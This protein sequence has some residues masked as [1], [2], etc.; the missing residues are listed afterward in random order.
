MKQFILI[1]FCFISF[2]ALAG[3]IVFK[4]SSYNAISAIY[5]PVKKKVVFETSIAPEMSCVYL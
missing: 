5:H 4:E 1:A 3:E 2:T